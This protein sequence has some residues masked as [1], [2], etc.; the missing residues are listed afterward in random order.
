MN[1]KNYGQRNSFKLHFEIIFQETEAHTQKS[2]SREFLSSCRK[3][4]E[5][6][7]GESKHWRESNTLKIIYEK[8]KNGL[9]GTFPRNLVMWQLQRPPWLYSQIA[10]CFIPQMQA[11]PIFED[12]MWMTSLDL[13]NLNH[14][15]TIKMIFINLNFHN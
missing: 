11:L 7:S 2:R 4:M 6:T 12:R 9:W 10:S 8:I 13:Q 1:F 5:N 15:T 14:R 3:K